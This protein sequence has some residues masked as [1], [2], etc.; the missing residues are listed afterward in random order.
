VQEFEEA[1]E[2]GDSVYHLKSFFLS[3]S[4]FAHETAAEGYDP[5]G[6]LDHRNDRSSNREDFRHFVSHTRRRIRRVEA[7]LTFPIVRRNDLRGD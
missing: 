4:Y 6:D 3:A 1:F 7:S 5:V 2:S